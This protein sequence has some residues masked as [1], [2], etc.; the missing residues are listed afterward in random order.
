MTENVFPVHLDSAVWKEAAEDS[1]LY[2]IQN[3]ASS[4][5][6]WTLEKGDQLEAR[7]AFIEG[8]FAGQEMI[9]DKLNDMNLLDRL[10]ELEEL[11]DNID[12]GDR[13]VL[14]L[15]Q[16]GTLLADISERLSDLLD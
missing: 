3:A 7:E 13:V 9:L 1:D 8:A 6:P 12:T 2:K 15:K 16:A 14:E 4:A 11:L 5:Y 10:Y